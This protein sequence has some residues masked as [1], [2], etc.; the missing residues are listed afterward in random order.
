MEI[1]K[2]TIATH[3]TAPHEMELDSTFEWQL[4]FQTVHIQLFEMY[5]SCI[6]CHHIPKFFGPKLG[7]LLFNGAK[8]DTVIMDFM[9]EMSLKI[10]CSQMKE[11][12]TM[13][14]MEWPLRRPRILGP[15]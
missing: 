8:R 10:Y 1:L 14:W 2:E 6:C 4:L 9:V 15:E 7:W 12:L 3:S 13:K 11:V 5:I